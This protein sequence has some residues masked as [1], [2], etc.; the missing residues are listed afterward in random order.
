MSNVETVPSAIYGT[1]YVLR[2]DAYLDYALEA[3]A[4]YTKDDGVI[5]AIASEEGPIYVTREQAKAFFG[6]VEPNEK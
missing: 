6:L 3:L 1:F 2:Q 4:V 5:L